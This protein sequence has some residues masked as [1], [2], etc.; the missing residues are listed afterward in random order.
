MINVAPN[1]LIPGTAPVDIFDQIRD[2]IRFVAAQSSH[3][4]IREDRLTEYA[5]SLQPRPPSNTLDGDHHYTSVNAE[6]LAA[7]ILCLE[8]VNFGSGYEDDLVAEGWPRIDNSLYFTISTALKKAFM[9]NGPWT[10]KTLRA[11]TIDDIHDIFMLPRARMGQSLAAMFTLSLKEIGA[12]VDE[13]YSGMFMNLVDDCGGMAS[14]LV[15]ILGQL[16]GYRDVHDYHGRDIMFYKRAQIAAADLNIALT[17]IG[18]PGFTD[19][20]RLTIFADNGLPMVLR[21]DSILELSDDLVRRIDTRALIPSGSDEE[22]ELRACAA[23][24]V[25]RLASIKGMGVVDLDHLLWHRSVED[26]RY[27]TTPAHRTI[28]RFY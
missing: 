10:A 9:E 15:R 2:G 12:L 19:I 13:S 6:D 1:L 5:L 4:R 17:R 26:P 11:L 25:E 20:D 24:A 14:R 28:S 8:A 3:V 16:A 7:Y 18:H 23:Q 27:V 22:I 21:V